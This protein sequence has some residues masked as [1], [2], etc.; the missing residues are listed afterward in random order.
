MSKSNAPLN[1]EEAEFKLEQWLICGAPEFYFYNLIG[2][3]EITKPYTALGH[4]GLQRSLSN[5]LY[6]QWFSG[7][8]QY[9]NSYTQALKDF[10]TVWDLGNKTVF[11]IDLP[12]DNDLE[13]VIELKQKWNT[14]YV[15]TFA[16]EQIGI[17][18]VK[19]FKYLED[20]ARSINQRYINS[21]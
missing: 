20:L 9:A 8:F 18:G 13:Y 21:Y 5:V 19:S 7:H 17:E 11:G 4:I 6:R 15:E 12:A 3:E 14:D 16:S 1:V 10:R 2:R